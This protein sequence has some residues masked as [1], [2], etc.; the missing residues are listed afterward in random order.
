MNR[1]ETPSGSQSDVNLNGQ[2]NNQNGWNPNWENKD[3][4]DLNNQNGW[5]KNS[6]P[7]ERFK[8]INEKAKIL[9]DKLKIFEAEKSKLEEEKLKIENTNKLDNQN[10]NWQNPWNNPNWDMWKI[11]TKKE[12]WEMSVEEYRKNKDKIWEQYQKWLIK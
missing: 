3:K 8:E 1:E 2:N 6:I 9:E 11:F 4:I 10:W 7:Y 5:E 12:I